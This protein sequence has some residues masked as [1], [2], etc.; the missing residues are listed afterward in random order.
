[1]PKHR[2]PRASVSKRPTPDN[3]DPGVLIAL[4]YDDLIEVEALAITADEASRSCRRD[5]RA[6]T[7]GP[8][9]GSTRWSAR[10]PAGPARCS[11]EARSWSPCARPTWRPRPRGARG[12]PGALTRASR[13]DRLWLATG[14]RA[15]DD[16][17]RVPPKN[18]RPA[19]PTRRALTPAARAV[20]RS[21]LQIF[22]YLR[23]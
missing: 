6:S 5:R 22:Q 17:A 15:S 19:G 23:G 10:P 12:T 16:L 13:P 14:D 20:L 7:A 8:C 2:N 1:M 3:P 21:H 4:L 11:N 18:P 9:P